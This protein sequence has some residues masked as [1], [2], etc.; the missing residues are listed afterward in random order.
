MNCLALET[1]AGILVIDCGV[2]F[3]HD[4]RGV[5]VIHPDFAYLWDRRE[6]VLGIVITH[7]HEDHIGGL[8]Y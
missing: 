6:E 7:G 2:T 8:P 5:D 1:P 3:P 4:D